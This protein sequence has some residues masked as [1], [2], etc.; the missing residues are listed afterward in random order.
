MSFQETTHL[1][2]GPNRKQKTPRQKDTNRGAVADSFT[3]RP[4]NQKGKSKKNKT[5]EPGVSRQNSYLINSYQIYRLESRS[6]S[7]IV[8]LPRLTKKSQRGGNCFN[9]CSDFN[10]SSRLCHTNNDMP[11]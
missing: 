1:A 8:S 6:L 11:C 3:P 9:T 5:K 10:Q 2:R 7:S 4:S